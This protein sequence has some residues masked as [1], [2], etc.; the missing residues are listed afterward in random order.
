V[1]VALAA[2]AC[3]SQRT[4]AGPSWQLTGGFGAGVDI[5]SVGADPWVAVGSSTGADGQPD[6]A[7]YLSAD[8]RSWRPCGLVPVDTDGYHTRLLG[9]AHLG[10][11][12]FAGG[13]AVGALHGNPRPYLWSGPLAGPLT[14]G[15]LPRE[16]FGGERIISFTGLSAGLL[17]G[18]GAGTW[19]GVTNQVV[20]QIWRTTDGSNWQRLDGV[21][22]LTS[23]PDEIL[24]GQ[25]VAVGPERVVLAGASLDLHR[26]DDGDDGAIWW[27]DD[28]TR[29]VRADLAGAGMGGPGYQELRVVSPA[30]AG[31]TVGGANGA[32]AAIWSSVDG[33]RWQSAHPLPGGSGRGATVTALAAGPQRQQWAGGV[34]DGVPRLWRSTD[35]RNWATVALPAGVR[36]AGSA[37]AVTLAYG[38]GQLLVV[39]QGS[40]G[41]VAALTPT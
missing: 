28:G 1:A 7:C 36:A 10:S 12:L 15:N 13:V 3:S 16:L 35:G 22:S 41:S 20:A 26:L 9:V 23:T 30:G 25:A 29:W 11:T 2:S 37:Q 8:G 21:Q 18:F 17:G 19:D 27:S 33:K 6:T 31:F 14:E 38:A 34:V 40:N 4:A 5:T 32:R 24:R 39:V